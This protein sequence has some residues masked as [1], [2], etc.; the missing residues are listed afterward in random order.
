MMQH[1]LCWL[2]IEEYSKVTRKLVIFTLKRQTFTKQVYFSR[3]NTIWLHLKENCQSL[4]LLAALW[5]DFVPSLPLNW[6]RKCLSILFLFCPDGTYIGTNALQ[7]IWTLSGYW[8]ISKVGM[9]ER[10]NKTCIT[11]WKNKAWFFRSPNFSKPLDH[12]PT[13]KQCMSS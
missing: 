9:H 10:T 1:G 6:T 13:V 12:D 4:F 8:P 11:S 5:K 3:S 7:K 2:R